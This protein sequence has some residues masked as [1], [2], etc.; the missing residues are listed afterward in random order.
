MEAGPGLA[1]VSIL[2]VLLEVGAAAATWARHSALTG[3]SIAFVLVLYPSV[4]TG[5]WS[6][7]MAVLLALTASTHLAAR[8]VEPSVDRF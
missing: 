1:A 7:H 2:W 8:A 3:V 6:L 5:T 4:Y